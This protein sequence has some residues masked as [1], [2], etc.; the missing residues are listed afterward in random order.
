MDTGV[1]VGGLLLLVLVAVA[2]GLIGGDEHTARAR[3]WRDIARERRRNWE[4]RR[5]TEELL[6][7]ID[8]C[9]ACPFRVRDRG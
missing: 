5:E 6:Q 4:E 8:R 3:A 7:T 2:I 9:R 1:I